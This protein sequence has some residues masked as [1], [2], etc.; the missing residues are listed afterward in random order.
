MSDLYKKLKNKLISLELKPNDKLS[1]N[2]IA[3]EEGIGRPQVRNILTSLS[4]EGYLTT[5]PQKGSVVNA[6]SKNM[7]RE[8]SH[9]HLILEQA[10]LMELVNKRKNGDELKLVNESAKKIRDAAKLK[11]SLA[12]VQLEWEFYNSLA[13]ECNREYAYS[14]LSK[15]DCDLLRVSTLRYST[16][17]YSLYASSLSAWENRLVEIRLLTDQINNCQ[18]DSAT[19]LCSNRYSG[20]LVATDALSSI[21]GD[22]F[23][24]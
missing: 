3:L 15:M 12:Q 9:A 8:S 13:R 11:D 17:N 1:E 22:Y 14:F 21:Y 4:E 24:Q 6:I 19:L 18:Y 23:E 5:L 2:S 20:L 16:Y 10:I 7:I